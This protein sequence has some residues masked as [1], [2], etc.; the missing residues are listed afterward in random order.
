MIILLKFREV[1]DLHSVRK[2]LE[3]PEGTCLDSLSAKNITPQKI[4][5]ENGLLVSF[6]YLNDETL[7][8]YYGG[9]ISIN[10]LITYP[11]IIAANIILSEKQM[12][13][14][15]LD[16]MTEEDIYQILLPFI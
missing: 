12:P 15:T 4:V 10:S 6:W 9:N 1:E 13:S 11:G 7:I 3:K 8:Q 14:N 5:I 2:F 16:V